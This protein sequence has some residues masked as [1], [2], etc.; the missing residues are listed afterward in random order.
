MTEAVQA[1]AEKSSE[2]EPLKVEAAPAVGPQPEE[3]A[4]VAES[5]SGSAAKPEGRKRGRPKKTESE[6][7]TEKKTPVATGKR[8]KSLFDF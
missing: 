1:S 2:T 8:Q 3:P 4:V 5:Q 6:G 7:K